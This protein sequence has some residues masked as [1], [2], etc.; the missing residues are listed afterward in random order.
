MI[1][2]RR[3]LLFVLV[4]TTG[5]SLGAQ[6]AR[7][8]SV[9]VLI[10]EA[11]QRV[12]KLDSEI[13]RRLLQ[14]FRNQVQAS[15]YRLRIKDLQ[16]QWQ[17]L[18]AQV[19]LK[20][21]KVDLPPVGPNEFRIE[22]AAGSDAADLDRAMVT[23]SCKRRKGC[24]VWAKIAFGKKLR[25]KGLTAR[26]WAEIKNKKGTKRLAVPAKELPVDRDEL[27]ISLDIS[28]LAIYKDQFEGRLQVVCDGRYKAKTFEFVLLNTF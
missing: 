27:V 20:R 11:R 5:A 18:F 16:Q 23:A 4:A 25:K 14:L 6:L 3:L 15:V 10:A 19:G 26:V 22:E 24:R 12:K 13:D 1:I 8:Q 28:K 21:K 17:S 9:D 7:A 2:Q